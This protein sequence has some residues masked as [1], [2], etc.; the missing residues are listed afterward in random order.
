MKRYRFWLFLLSACL[1]ILAA[2]SSGTATTSS[3]PAASA[4]PVASS[5]PASSPSAPPA[6]PPPSSASGS[7]STAPSTGY[8]EIDGQRAHQVVVPKPAAAA[9]YAVTTAGIY[10]NTNGAWSKVADDNGAGMIVADPT[11]SEILYRGDHPGCA[12]GGQPIAFQKSTDGGKTWTTIPGVQNTQPM[13]VDPANPSIVY[14]NSC[15]LAVSTNAGQTWKTVQPLPSFDLSSL[16]LA[17]NKLYGVYTS[18]GGTSRLIVSDVSDPN[19]P[20]GNNQLLEFWGGGTVS[21][22]AG[23]LIVGEPHGVHVSTDGGQHWTFSRSGLED[24]TVSVNVLTEPLPQNEISTGFGIFAATIHPEQS[25]RLEAG[26]IRGLY[27]SQDNGRTW[28]QVPE[29]EKSKVRDLAFASNG[30][31]LYVTTDD[32]I[33]VLNNQ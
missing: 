7:P 6:S 19:N 21:A 27:R 4:P 11:N 12:I 1:L 2:C 31:Q 23:K 9:E 30:G 13:I 22:N 28:A 18:E 20:T 8:L 24:V 5:S 33:Y 32:G 3:S 17:G 25:D 10:R 29:I 15:A 14:G 26:T 16:A